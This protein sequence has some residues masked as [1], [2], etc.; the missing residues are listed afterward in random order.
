VSTIPKQLLIRRTGTTRTGRS[1][2]ERTINAVWNK[3]T[4]VLGASPAALRKDI[5]GAWI[6][7]SRYGETVSEGKGWEIDHI[8]PVSR[9]G[10][11]D[12]S[13]LQALQWQNNRRKGD[14]FPIMPAAFAAVVARNNN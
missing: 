6:E 3:A 2:D 14:S 8:I 5:C 1:F 11:D 12:L 4:A 10:T 7:C 13:N 9:G